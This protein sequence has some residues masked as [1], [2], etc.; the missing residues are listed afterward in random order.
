MESFLYVYIVLR[1]IRYMRNI[2]EYYMENYPTDELG[3]EIN[4]E[5]TFTGLYTVLRISGEV[6]EYIGV[7]DS[8]IRERCFERLAE[9]AGVSYDEIYS[10]WV[11][12]A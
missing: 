7:G 5:A 4:P 12:A 11:V 3:A 1:D 8:L 2:R 10:K 9:I 6:Y